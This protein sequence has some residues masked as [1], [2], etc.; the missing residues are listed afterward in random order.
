MEFGFKCTT[1][2]VVSSNQAKDTQGQRKMEKVLE[3]WNHMDG[4]ATM[5]S[6]QT[7]HWS[8]CFTTAM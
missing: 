6:S 8:S 4:F 1:V 2:R 3:M 5:L 7:S